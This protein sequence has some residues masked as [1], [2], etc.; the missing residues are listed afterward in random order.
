M[1][2]STCALIAVIV[3]SIIVGAIKINTVEST[4]E[5]N[6]IQK[7]SI[8]EF[9]VK[10]TNKTIEIKITNQPFKTYYN[11]SRDWNIKFYYNIQVKEHNTQE[12]I[13]LYRP[14]DG[15]PHQDSE[16][17][18]TT[19]T[20]TSDRMGTKILT[21]SA[22]SKVEFQVQ[23]MIGYVH[24]DASSYLAPWIFTGE[25]SGWSETQ[26]VT[27][28]IAFPSPTSSPT[29]PNNGPTSPPTSPTPLRAEAIVG[30][31][32]IIL[33]L[34]TAIVFFLYLMKKK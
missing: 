22:G 1:K 18:Y 2:A 3:F 25:T 9:E 21:F 4:T 15:Y 26:T 8:P 24:R 29:P 11:E 23:A 5:L 28:N 27:L 30:A 13:E 20:Y 34:G 6:H 17:E 32:I 10:A 14:S 7:P 33:V 16:L 19:I 31:S 12:W